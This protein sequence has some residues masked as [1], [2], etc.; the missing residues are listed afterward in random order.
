MDQL[1][2]LDASNYLYSAYFAIRNMTNAKGE[3]TNALFGFARSVLKLI[4]EFH[5][6]HMVV[7]FDGPNNA[8]KRLAVYPSY[9]AHRQ[10]MPLDLREQIHKAQHLCSL[11]N[12]PWLA[13]PE[14]EA[15]DVIGSIAHWAKAETPMVYLCSADKDLCQCVDDRVRVLNT[16]KDN[17]VIG[18]EEVKALHGIEPGQMIDYLALVGDASDNVPGLPGFGPKTASK[19]LQQ[20]GTLDNILAHPDKI[21]ENKKRET[22]LQQ[23]E[24]ARLSRQLVTI[25]LGV[26]V[27]HDESFFAVGKPQYSDLKSFYSEMNF[28]SLL[29]E[30][31]QLQAQDMP[32]TVNLNYQ[33]VDDEASFL[34][35]LDTLQQ[36]TE[37]C[38]DVETTALN[39]I[40]A[41]LVGLGFG[42]E[43]GRAWY[44]PVNG[45]LGLD[46]VLS[47]LKP[48]FENAKLGF[49]G[50]NVKY[51]LQVLAN[52][53]IHVANICFDTILAS[54]LLNSQSRQH[55]L[56]ALTLEHYGKVKIDIK[57]LIGKGKTA[58]TMWQV[59]IPQVCNYCCEDVDCTV[60]LKGLLS[61]QITE[62]G[63]AHLL[64]DL[65]LPLIK[66]LAAMERHGIYC[67]KQFLATIGKEIAVQI[68]GLQ[69][70]I[71]MLAG[72]EFNLNSPVQLEVIFKKLGMRSGKKTP[73]GRMKIDSD[74][75]E[76]L[77]QQY[78]IA[79]LLLEYRGIEKLRSTYVEALPGCINSKTGRI[80]CTFNQVVAATGR[81]SCQDP[82]LQNIPIR[83]AAGRRIRE[84]FLPQKPGWS[85]LSADYSQ[86]ELRLLA[87]FS[88]D[89][90]L[91][92]AFHNNQDV[93]S[94]TASVIL[95]VPLESVTKEQ[96]HQ[97]KAV[98]FGII[99]GQQAFG[100]SQELSISVKE[101]AAFIEMYFQRYNRVQSFLEG[102]KEK[103][104]QTGKAVTLIGRERAIPEILSKNG[105]L[106][107]LAE[108]LAINTPLQG[109]AADIIKMAM[110]KVQDSLQKRKLKGFM[111]LQIH[112]ELIF[113]VPDEE[114]EETEQL[115]RESMQQ[116]VQLQ[117]PLIV[118][119]AIG[120]NWKEC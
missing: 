49:Y 91:L 45:Q 119:I 13:I 40:E 100:L 12:F 4:K 20:F 71:F 27:P 70:S 10:A 69:K 118:D 115:V 19:L 30:L 86:I 82:N 80:H 79:A 102:C 35:L 65:E 78:P 17:L 114:L 39:P 37:I 97:A 8:K 67:D 93:H 111:I 72:E 26:D 2:I 120:K 14:V 90:N 83:T 41:D 55:S 104:R 33:L 117:V 21:T 16:Q 66:I 106:R 75:L 50:H 60:K 108:R 48:L 15:D 68:E 42:F 64:F 56:D 77:K 32:V 84:A 107:S 9:K 113:E 22:L 29:K 11:L 24:L 62:R 34:A 44:V 81:L 53:N 47:G 6:K 54:Y 7:V 112:D 63:L 5:P 31:E 88:S 105:S 85:Y 23:S 43:E 36:Q 28:N 99:Y 59:P 95:N 76:G 73:T 89:P 52:Y 3:S 61:K 74:V 25:D 110:L 1:F 94:H 51:D 18:P 96:R 109:T 46:R 98:N 92:H 101:A 38:F 58:I 57:E 116:V 87:H 103:A